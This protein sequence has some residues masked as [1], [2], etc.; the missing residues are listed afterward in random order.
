MNALDSHTPEA[1]DIAVVG[2]GLVGRPL[3][4]A[5][6]A[7][8]WTVALIDKQ[9]DE[10]RLPEPEALEQSCTALSAGT[11]DWLAQQGFW[12][13]DVATAAPIREVHVSQ[14]GFLGAT[15]I[16]ASDA[17]REALG[18]TIENRCFRHSL[19]AQLASSD[20]QQWRG[21]AVSAIEE[22]P[23][24]TLK[25]DVSQAAVTL[26]LRPEG[27]GDAARLRARL[28]LIADGVRSP[29]AQLLGSSFKEVDHRQYATLATVRMDRDHKAIA[30]ERFTA[31]GPLATLPRPHSLVSVVACHDEREAE[32]VDTLNEACFLDWLAERQ[33][34][35]AGRPLA[36]GPRLQLPLRRI[37]ADRQRIGR[38]LLLG[39]AARLLH[40]VA[41]QGYNLAIRDVASLVAALA[42]GHD[43]GES[44][45][46][47]AWLESRRNDQT[48]TVGLTDSL[49]RAFRGESAWLGH[50]RATGL[51]ALDAMGPARRAFA[52]RTTQGPLF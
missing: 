25:A 15:R 20:V 39:N 11:V 32:Y 48:S 24:A 9:A 10:P 22:R 50:L 42:P 5:L 27:A 17:R 4:L 52:A 14:R 16:H 19:A 2:D 3:A 8:G 23:D 45:T 34:R 33:Q 40:P 12:H 51:L 31:S 6:Y 37:E 49:A 7:Q 38:C 44:A 30:R 28:V 29:T 46:L 18:W 36:V 1:V 21:Y 41:G 43:P 13:P 26:N 35:R 47:D